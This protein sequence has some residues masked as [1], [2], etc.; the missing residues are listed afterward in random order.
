VTRIFASELGVQYAFQPV[1]DLNSADST[2][3]GGNPAL[4]VPILRTPGGVWFG[5]LNIC[6][7]LARQAA[8]KRSIVWPEDLDQPLLANAQEL[9]VQAM[10]TGVSLIMAGA[11]GEADVQGHP[12]KLRTSLLNMLSWLETN[13]KAALAQLPSERDLSFLEVTLFCLI[14]HLE[15]RK[16]VPTIA[17]SALNDFCRSFGGRQSAE[18]T[19]FRFDA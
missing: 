17:Y 5:A 8:V 4:R 11:A 3:Y 14:T 7:E 19:V 1:L 18:A 15:F 12:A 2:D 13:A 10:S 9:T 6:R 16:V